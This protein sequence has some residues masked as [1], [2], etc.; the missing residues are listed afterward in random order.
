MSCNG[1]TAEKEI[2]AITQKEGAVQQIKDLC[3][4]HEAN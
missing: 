2:V 3:M 1:S 4:H